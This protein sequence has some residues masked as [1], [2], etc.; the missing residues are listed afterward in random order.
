MTR[1]KTGDFGNALCFVGWLSEL[2]EGYVDLQKTEAVLFSRFMTDK[3]ALIFLRMA[4]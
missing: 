4:V 3:T 1:K 2:Y